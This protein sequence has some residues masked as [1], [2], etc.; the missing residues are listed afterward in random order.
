MQDKTFEPGKRA[1]DK[2]ITSVRITRDIMFDTSKKNNHTVEVLE[3]FDHSS[4]STIKDTEFLAT[5]KKILQKFDLL[6]VP[7]LSIAF[8]FCNLDKANIGNAEVNGLS[9][10]LGLVGNQYGNA[11]SLLYVTYVIFETPVALGLK[12]IGPKYLFAGMYFIFGLCCMCTAFV[13]NYGTLVACRMLVG[14]FE[15]GMIPCI[16]VYLG[17][18]YTRSEM[19]KRCAVVY[20][21]GALAGAF[22]GLLAYGI[23]HMDGVGGW[24]GWRWLFLIEGLLTMIFF[25][26]MVALL[27]TDPRT[28]KW[29]TPKEREV[30]ATRMETYPEFYQDEKFTWSEVYR[31][32]K[33]YRTWLI[34]L[35]QFGAD[36]TVFSI[37]TFIPSII[38]GMGF[39]SYRTQLLTIPIYA[40]A[41][42][43]YYVVATISDRIGIRGFFVS[44]ACVVII[45]GYAILIGA[46]SLGAR[47]FG[48]ILTGLFMYV[49]NGLSCMWFNNN[50][51]G[52]YKRATTAG[53]ITT[54][55]NTGGVLAGQIFTADTAPRYYKGLKI[56]LSLTCASLVLCCL[57]IFSFDKENKRRAVLVE[58][59][60][61]EEEKVSQSDESLRFK[62]LL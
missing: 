28:A 49:G 15:S 31:S 27:P 44:G 52:H 59:G 14:L 11:V 1:A 37:S 42:I 56:N 9:Q 16:N 34:S 57:C 18:L 32:V 22:G 10:D 41:A 12:K 20:A 8:L 6:I 50:S 7:W 5:E 58:Q 46:D 40:L 35:Y 45:V 60:V 21:F 62:F 23:L 33:E 3:D 29:L 2:P 47:Y 36:L 61:E 4:A 30:L 53:L 25:P 51:A 43:A 48:C 55:G 39:T 19:A 38:R 13:T 26:P 17:M 24:A 54:I